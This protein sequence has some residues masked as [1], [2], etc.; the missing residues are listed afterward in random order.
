MCVTYV[1]KSFLV[2][3]LHGFISVAPRC[4]CFA[5]EGS[6]AKVSIIFWR[7]IRPSHVAGMPG[8]GNHWEPVASPDQQTCKH[9]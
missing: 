4:R 2:A 3:W 5:V 1:Y 6:T 9:M 8:T 7:P